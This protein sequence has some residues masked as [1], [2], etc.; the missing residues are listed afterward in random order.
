MKKILLAIVV[1]SACNAVHA[2]GTLP[3][4]GK[5]N[6]ADLQLKECAFDK[7]ADAMNLIKTEKVRFDIDN[8]GNAKTYT[9]YRI[10]IKIFK[11]SGFKNASIVIP[12]AGNSR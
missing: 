6:M 2:Q 10:R 7:G 9:E 4:F 8:M 11:E 12:Y 1:F 5:I 3:E